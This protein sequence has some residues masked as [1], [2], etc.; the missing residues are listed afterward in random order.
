M[1][2]S[3]LRTLLLIREIHGEI[4]GRFQYFFSLLVICD[5]VCTNMDIVIRRYYRENQT[6]RAEILS[7]NIV[8]KLIVFLVSVL[9][10]SLYLYYR[11]VFSSS[12]S[13]FG[14]VVLIFL[15][16][17]IGLL[18]NTFSSS[19]Q[20][21]SKYRLVN[22]VENISNALLLISVL[23][24]SKIFSLQDITLLLWM[25]V[26]WV[27]I[28][29]FGL[30]TTFYVF[31]RE[32]EPFR[33][34]FNQKAFRV[35]F[36]NFRG[37]FLPLLGTNLSGYIKLYLPAVLLGEN[38]QFQQIAYFEVTKKIFGVI[39]KLVPSILL[40]LI[41]SLS[42]AKQDEHFYETW[43]RGMFLYFLVNFSFCIFIFFG[44]PWVFHF[45]KIQWNQEISNIILIF[46]FGLILGSWVQA[47]Q[48]LIFITYT[49]KLI[50]Y[51]SILRQGA[52]LI[53]MMFIFNKI[54][55]TSLAI[56][57]NGMHIPTIILFVFSVYKNQRN[58]LYLEKRYFI[59]TTTFMMLVSSV[60]IFFR[61]FVF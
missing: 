50:L 49:T 13:W 2:F 8:I 28:I 1:L 17:F 61:P 20:A 51:S 29:F 56:G 53:Y 19:L 7:V 26:A 55:P 34:V 48:M 11:N 58:M 30:V 38:L 43:S 57:I 23:I 59:W 25:N 15:R 4:Y 54:N 40:S 39:Y 10:I 32:S 3:F 9:I 44:G 22:Y 41:S 27:C 31:W 12:D 46:S 52:F 47:N 36:W 6:L 16:I 45:Y 33:F 21:L 5:F 60:Y 18:K 24:L 14:I 42:T 37:Y 35:G